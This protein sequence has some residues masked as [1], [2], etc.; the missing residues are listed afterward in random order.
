MKS[1]RRWGIRKRLILAFVGVL[2]P[3]LMLVG[4]GV[5]GFSLLWGTIR[6]IEEEAVREIAAAADLQI[7]LLNV[8]MPANDYL[9]TGDATERDEF[10]RRLGRVR[11]VLARV[12]RLHLHAPEERRALAEVR[13]RL[14]RIEALSRE[15]LA[16]NDPRSDRAAPAKMKALDALGEEAAAALG[17][18][19]EASEREIAEEI[20][21]SVSRMWQVAGIGL[22]LVILSVAGGV[23]L[24]LVFARWIGGPLE[25]IAEGSRRMA[26]GDLS[27]RVEESG[28]AELGETARAFNRMA[29]EMGEG[30]SRLE[31]RVAELAALFETGRIL[32]GTL[33][34]SGVLRRLAGIA[35][36]RLGM[37][38][39]R[40]LVRDP[41]SGLLVHHTH[42]G[43]TRHD[44]EFQTR[45]QVG[46][47]LPGWGVEHRAIV[48][49][50]DVLKDPRTRNRAWME[51]EG[52]VSYLGV[53]LLVGNSAVGFLACMS[54]TRRDFAPEEI[55]LAEA[56][57]SQ[58]AVAIENARLFEESK[59]RLRAAEALAAVG[60]DLGQSLDLAVVG[61]RIT[62]R[63]RELL[64]LPFSALYRLEP[65]SGDLAALAVSE[66]VASSLGR[67]MV[68]ARGIGAT[69]LAVS[70]G[71]PVAS[72]D[73]LAD[74]RLTFTPEVRIR[75]EQ[76]QFRAV[77]A[78]PLLV[79]DRVIGALAV[80]EQAGRV[81]N[82]E[83]IQ[84]AEAFAGQAALALKNARLFDEARRALADLK[85]AEEQL[86]RDSTLRAL[87]EL[88][89]G[90]AH[91][92]NNLLAIVLGRV[93]LL[94]SSLE[95][96]P[97]PRPLAIIERATMDAA[98]VVRRVLRFARQQPLEE[99]VAVDLKRLAAEVREMARPR[100]QD[101]G[102]ARGLEIQVVVEGEDVPPIAGNPS[103]LLEV[104][105]NLVLN[106]V[107]ALPDGGR[108]VLRTFREGSWVGVAVTD[109]G[110]GMSPEVRA[111]VLQPFFTTKGPKSTGLGLSVAYGTLQR[112]GGGLT[113]ESEEGRGTTIT[114]RLPVASPPRD[115][116]DPAEGAQ[117]PA[118][119]ILL[120]ED[121]EEV[122]EILGEMLTSQGHKVLE[123]GGGR[124]GLALLEAGEAVDLVLTDLGMPGMAGWEVAQAIKARWPR[125]PVGVLTGWGDAID[126]ASAEGQAVAGVLSKPITPECLRQFVASCY[127]RHS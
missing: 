2:V 120:I 68:F 81:F 37:D 44:I 28:G 6:E 9:I 80:G 26:E 113:I 33:D 118:L 69:G 53:P 110:V 95:S 10:G 127:V 82:D 4:V 46:E 15:L 79:E 92:L 93:R 84:L 22:A 108:I 12:E 38:V 7:A 97:A 1:L 52:I 62:D 63:I 3:Y 76:A 58:A 13:G 40:I 34:L 109:N 106:A 70:E 115:E 14:G 57:A 78:V 83:E 25:S 64:H 123:A 18:F 111:Q 27:A 104:L 119:Y 77:L 55:A 73:V 39:I 31:Q 59:Q 121:D 112:H 19:R 29:A 48:I 65:E 47:G 99:R 61:R 107:D 125:L 11:E 85:V 122:R 51:S 71:R 91:H 87:G 32:T 56:L 36:T 86:I 21:R 17:R 16:L 8:L 98:E 117:V 124:Q 94:Q 105:L 35:R 23:G 101:A 90:A 49:A 24:A 30:R 50:A 126:E 72:E 102:H 100:W 20:E 103:A 67:E 66:N 60:R 116:R 41:A 89:A 43:V 96:A 114:I 45:F 74:P 5:A 88:A 75:V 42:E 54:R